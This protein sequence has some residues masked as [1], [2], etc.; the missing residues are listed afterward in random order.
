MSDQ[1]QTELRVQLARLQIDHADLDLA[2]DALIQTG[3]N[4]ICIQR[5]KKKKLALKDQI[6]KL[7]S[8]AMPDII[9]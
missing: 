4:A 8:L 3:A 7:H 6:T 1:D 5:F 2:I 9:A